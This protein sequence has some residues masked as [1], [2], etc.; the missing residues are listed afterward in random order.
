MLDWHVLG[1]FRIRHF[2]GDK[3][4]REELGLNPGPHSAQM[5][6]LTTK[7]WFH[8]HLTLSFC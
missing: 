8:G 2:R 5:T 1:L 6:A 4:D 7:V 3:N